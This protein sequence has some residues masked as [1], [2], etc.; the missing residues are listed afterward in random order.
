MKGQYNP[1]NRDELKSK[2]ATIFGEN[3]QVLS[4]E[5]QEMLLDDLVTA[6]ENRVKVLNRVQSS[7]HFEI[8]ESTEYETVQT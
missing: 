7:V 6:F 5:L 1:K 8:A 3:I 4:K 2:I